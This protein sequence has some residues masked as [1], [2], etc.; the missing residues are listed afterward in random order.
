LFQSIQGWL[1]LRWRASAAIIG[2]EHNSGYFVHPQAVASSAARP[3]HTLLPVK[4]ENPILVYNRNTFAQM[5]T[6]LSRQPMVA[7]DTE[8]DSLYRYYPRVCLIQITT[9]ADGHPSDSTL[10]DYLVDPL[11]WGELQPL[12]LVL[13]NPKI[14][15]VMHASENDIFTLQR[16]FGFTFQNLFDIQLA[17]RILGWKRLGL[18]SILEEQFGVIS[19]KRMQRTN[20]GK[21]PL[22]PQQI[23]YA[24]M[25]THYLPALRTRLAT[26][27]VECGR[28][29]EA[30]EAFA[31]LSRLRYDA[32]NDPP[33]T[34]WQMKGIR[35]HAPE[36]LGPLAALWAWRER[37]AQRRDLPPFKIIND[38]TMVALA[39]KRPV[40]L[41]QLQEVRGLSAYQMQS[42]G[43]A[44][45][46]AVEEGQ[47]TVPPPPPP[48]TSRPDQQLDAAA[49]RRLEALR[50]TQ[51]AAA[52]GVAPDV[53]FTNE[54]LLEIAQRRPHSEEELLKISAI[55]P[56][57]AKAYGPEVLRLMLRNR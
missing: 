38:E 52:R 15:K 14:E 20:W 8:S 28:W 36:V 54:T 47:R 57:K 17:A 12:E 6:H 10:V 2:C 49:E 21:R 37:E 32:R 53:V 18:A 4:N 31:Q 44:L 39:Q 46:R 40:T 9:Y 41:A 33:R 35:D 48:P 34:V 19:D 25:D 45:L 56:W 24:Q 5:M 55:G 7:L 27:L 50:R 1:D 23:A 51:T 42:I 30:Q 43:Q 3:N 22:T 26:E 13:A 16:G 29:E 11:R